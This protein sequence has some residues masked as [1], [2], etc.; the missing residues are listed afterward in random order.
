MDRLQDRPRDGCAPGAGDVLRDGCDQ[1]LC[2]FLAA[3]TDL[4]H[5]LFRG[6][7]A[8]G[9][10]RQLCAPVGHV[11]LGRHTC[12]APDTGGAGLP[13]RGLATTAVLRISAA[14]HD[15]L[16]PRARVRWFPQCRGRDFDPRPS[17][18]NSGAVRRSGRWGVARSADRCGLFRCGLRGAQPQPQAAGRYGGPGSG[19]SAG[20][21]A[22]PAGPPDPVHHVRRPALGVAHCPVGV[23]RF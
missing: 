20:F 6:V 18:T 21:C 12:R 4:S 13:W 19:Q 3:A 1:S 11:G 23:G 2:G 15:A 17:Q 7:P 22:G 8:G 5:A 9:L 16:Y 10:H 14:K